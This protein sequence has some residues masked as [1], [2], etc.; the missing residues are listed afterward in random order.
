MVYSDVASMTAS[1]QCIITFCFSLLSI[2]YALVP[3]VESHYVIIQL[4]FT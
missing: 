3:M 1:N 2:S 4:H